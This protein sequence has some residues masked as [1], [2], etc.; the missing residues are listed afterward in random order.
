MIKSPQVYGLTLC[1]RIRVEKTPPLFCLDGLFLVREFQAFP[2]PPQSF[3]VYATFFD[4]RGE[5]EMKLTLTR[6]EGEQDIRYHTRWYVFPQ[7]VQT[8]H[9]IQQVNNLIFD[10]PGRYALTLSFNKIPLTVRYLDVKEV[11]P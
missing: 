2:S 3:M 6:L 5:G 1:E 9:Y 4:G 10:E 7:Q 11:I 8:L